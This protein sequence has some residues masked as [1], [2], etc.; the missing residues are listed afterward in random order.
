MMISNMVVVSKLGPIRADMKDNMHMA[1]NMVLEITNGMMVA[2]TLVIGTK[3]RLVAS[4]STL[5]LMGAA[6]KVN[7]MRIIWK[8]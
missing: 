5:G 8:A 6:T 1:A 3:T 7:G 2:N 4:G